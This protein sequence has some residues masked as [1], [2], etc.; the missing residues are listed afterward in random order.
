M[1][2]DRRAQPNEPAKDPFTE[3][4][5]DLF[6]PAEQPE[7]DEPAQE[8]AA[9]YVPPEPEP[10]PRLPA[11]P[12][13]SDPTQVPQARPRR[14]L[15][16]VIII[17]CAGLVGLSIA[18]SAVL[19]V[20]GLIF[21][22]EE[23]PG[24]KPLPQ[25]IVEVDV[26]SRGTE[27]PAE[28]VPLGSPADLNSDWRVTVE[29]TIPDATDQVLARNQFNEPPEDGRQFF[30]ASVRV[31]N[32]GEDAQAFPATLCSSD[33]STTLGRSTQPSTITVASYLRNSPGKSCNRGR[34]PTATSAGPSTSGT[35]TP[36]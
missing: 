33:S 26:A 19:V 25:P 24:A 8:P 36:S 20:I 17:G 12:A 3:A 14:S 23:D 5:D 30:I 22:D 13:V 29:G 28:L 4:L 10:A 7:P 18:C 15:G 11:Y 32:R 21:G 1:N 31:E 9:T 27:V 6:G 2:D 35:S 16:R 34:S